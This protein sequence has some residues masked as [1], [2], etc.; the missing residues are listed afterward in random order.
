MT[1]ASRSTGT[2]PPSLGIVRPGGESGFPVPLAPTGRGV[3]MRG[4]RAGPTHIKSRPNTPSHPVRLFIIPGLRSLR[5][6]SSL[7]PGQV[8]Q[9]CRPVVAAGCQRVAVGRYGDTGRRAADDPRAAGV[10][11]LWPRPRASRNRNL[12]RR[13]R[14]CRSRES[15]GIDARTFFVALDGAC[16]HVDTCPCFRIPNPGCAVT[17]PRRHG[18]AVGAKATQK[19]PSG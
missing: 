16:D 19:T 15:D 10:P 8:P 11:D 5:P 13:P 14:S 1:A 4:P 9:K 3:R 7:V 17:V 18:L 6:R 2:I 12:P